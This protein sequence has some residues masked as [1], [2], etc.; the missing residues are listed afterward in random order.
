MQINPTDE[1]KPFLDHLDDLRKTIVRMAICVL[2]TTIVSFEFAPQLM[3]IIRRPV[4]KVW[5]EY[6]NIHL[7]QGVEADEW[8]QAKSLAYSLD[9][10]SDRARDEA[11]RLVPPR[12]RLLGEAAL[13]LRAVNQLPEASRETFMNSRLF[14]SEVRGM[15]KKLY[16]SDAVLNEGT[17]RGALKLMGAFQ[18]G[19]A[20]MLSF[21]LAFY[22]GI[23]LSFPFLLYFL[24]QFIV[25]GL[26]EKE[27]ALLYKCLVVAFALFLG[28]VAFAYW[29]VL[30]RVL[31]FF[32]TYSLD[33]GIANEWR[34]GYYVS[35]A[36]Q[37]V[38]LFGL[39]FELPVIVMPFVKMGLLSYELMKST[40]RYAVVAVFILAAII[41]PTPDIATMCLMAGPMYA[42][43]ELCILLAWRE[44]RAR[45]KREAEENLRVES[46]YGLR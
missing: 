20:F 46:D 26:L 32:Y 1:E 2:L 41:T 45:D 5:T 25:P 40:R 42:L 34:I 36:T 17:G 6:E 12:E 4:D 9:G 23:I 37:L 33:F 13:M 31:T 39:A 14:S 27:R 30:P 11:F 19:E 7:P 35:F 8:G 16:E 15:T 10:L 3:Q 22:A 38:L 43:Y 44:G 24:L 28:G 21:K 29:I 18:P